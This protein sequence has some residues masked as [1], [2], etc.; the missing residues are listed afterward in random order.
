MGRRTVRGRAN[1]EGSERDGRRG[2]CSCGG[3][4]RDPQVRGGVRT[5][6]VRCE[7]VLARDLGTTLAGLF[8]KLERDPG[9]T[10]GW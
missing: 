1:H 9:G 5:D 4:E 8:A 2:R 7:D 10:D 6:R 3:G